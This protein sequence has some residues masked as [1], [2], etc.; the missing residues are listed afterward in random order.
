MILDNGS[1][2]EDNSSTQVEATELCIEGD[3]S[4][5]RSSMRVNE[6]NH[7][8]ELCM[9][10]CSHIGSNMELEEHN[11]NPKPV[12]P[13][14]TSVKSQDF[15]R[16]APIFNGKF[17]TKNV[18]YKPIEHH[19]PNAFQFSAQQNKAYKIQKQC[20]RKNSQGRQRTSIL[21]PAQESNIGEN[22]Y[23]LKLFN[24]NSIAGIRKIAI[25]TSESTV[26][27]IMEIINSIKALI[28][29]IYVARGKLKGQGW[30]TPN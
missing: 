12:P 23:E 29:T 5:N 11:A 10:A 30:K 27:D 24:A 7:M 19:T 4:S 26:G 14:V 20:R 22:R 6:F 28:L 2:M 25:L 1:Y 3:N 13:D 21:R 9:G 17:A 16:S 15:M 8:E 18:V